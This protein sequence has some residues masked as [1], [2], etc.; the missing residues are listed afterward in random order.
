MW[1]GGGCRVIGGYKDG[2]RRETESFQTG[3]PLLS[4]GSSA[5]PAGGFM[6]RQGPT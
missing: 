6:G 4:G 3:C 5:G 1:Q 2:S